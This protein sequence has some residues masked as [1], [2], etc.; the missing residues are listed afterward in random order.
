MLEA[1]CTFGISRSRDL[2]FFAVPADAQ[3]ASSIDSDGRRLFINAEPPVHLRLD[4]AKRTN[5]FFRAK[6]RSSGARGPR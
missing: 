5:I 3:I 1:L 6:R 2:G 4:A